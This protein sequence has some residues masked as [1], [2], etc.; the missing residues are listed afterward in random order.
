MSI[1]ALLQTADMLPDRLADQRIK[2]HRTI[3]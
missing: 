1:P 2:S 3:T